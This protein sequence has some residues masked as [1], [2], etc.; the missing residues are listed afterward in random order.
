MFY[1]PARI[2]RLPVDIRGR[3]YIHWGTNF[4]TGFN[5]RIEAVPEAQEVSLVIGDNV[6]INDYVHI[7]AMKKVRIGDH[8][9]IASKVYISD[10]SHGSYSGD[11]NDTS[12]EIPPAERVLRASHVIIEDR[13]WLGEHV[14]VLPGVTIGRKH[15][16]FFA[17]DLVT[18]LKYIHCLLQ[19]LPGWK[20][21]ELSRKMLKRNC[22]KCSR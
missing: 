7:T 8:V 1:R 20:V 3:K 11:E 9:L 2:I 15:H 22:G 10:C 12:P 19:I 5:C 17:F 13:V 16:R 4:T 18:T 6:Q 21:P 14:S